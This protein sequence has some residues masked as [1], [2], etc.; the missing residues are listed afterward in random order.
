MSNWLDRSLAW[1]ATGGK[2]EQWQRT[3]DENDA[4]IVENWK[5]IISD[6]NTSEAERMS[7]ERELAAFEAERQN[8]PRVYEDSSVIFADEV[9]KQ[10]EKIASKVSGG[11]GS[12]L[13]WYVWLIIGLALLAYIIPFFLKRK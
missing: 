3:S 13:P 2:S 4:H 11:V 6:S 1:I 10:G 5:R 9:G 12:L 8:T 7:A